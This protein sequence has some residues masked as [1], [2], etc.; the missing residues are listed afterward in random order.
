MSGLDN[1]EKYSS[2]SNELLRLDILYHKMDNFVSENAFLSCKSQVS[3]SQ[4]WNP[5]S[6]TPSEGMIYQCHK[7]D[8]CHRLVL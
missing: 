3:P 4:S 5:T 8:S 1:E 7:P 2:L 6:H